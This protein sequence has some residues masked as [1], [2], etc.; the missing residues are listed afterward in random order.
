M[1]AELRQVIPAFLARVDQPDRGGRWI[2]YFAET[3]RGVRGARRGRSLDQ[4]S[5]AEP[6]GEVTLTDFDPDGEIKVV[7]A[8]LYSV[9][10]LPDDQLLAI[11]RRLSADD[12]AARPPRLRR[13]RAP[14]A[15]TSRAAR[16]S[17][18]ATASTSSPTTARS[19]ISSAIG[20]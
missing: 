16:S 14:T 19:A 8:A 4:A 9:S 6:R 5:L 1:L 15:A 2:E 10:A 7:A 17:A 20:C 12:R 11:A 18:P 13:R 3:R